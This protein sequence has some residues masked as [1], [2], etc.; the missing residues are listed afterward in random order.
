MKSLLTSVIFPAFVLA[1]DPAKGIIVAS[2]SNSLSTKHSLDT[3]FLM[4]SEWYRN[5]FHGTVISPYQNIKNK[6]LTTKL[7]FRFATSISGTLTGE[8]AD[9]I[10]A[11]DPI[12]ALQ[13]N[14]KTFRDKVK[15][16]FVNTF[17]TRLKHRRKSI[18]SK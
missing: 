17:M 5:K 9:I 2:Y 13:A 18:V 8:G 10:I 14:S 12:N 15:M 1:K 3:R 16:W 4:S 11:D 7:G 6:F